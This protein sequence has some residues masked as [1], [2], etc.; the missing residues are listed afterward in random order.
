MK[1]FKENGFTLPEMMIVVA[2]SGALILGGIKFFANKNSETTKI[3]T[4]MESTLDGLNF[5][6]LLRK[7]ISEA[8]YSY[9]ALLVKDDNN[10][11]F[12]DY[13]PEGKCTNN[14][15]RVI[16]LK[17]ST[18]AAEPSKEIYFIVKDSS[19]AVEQLYDPQD[20]YN[21]SAKK[22]DDDSN[23]TFVS[24]NNNGY[25]ALK[26]FTPWELTAQIKERLIFLYS[27]YLTYAPSA[28]FGQDIGKM[29]QYL[30]WLSEKN[31]SGRLVS[32]TIKT[33]MGDIFNNQD[34]RYGDVIN[35]ED[36][37]LRRVPYTSGLG[38]FVLVAPVKVIRFRIKSEAINGKIW[39]TL[40]KGTLLSNKTFFESVLASKVEQVQFKRDTISNGSID[41]IIKYQSLK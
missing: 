24:L 34:L 30:G 26:K 35:S 27:P 23:L 40:Y 11:I 10:K 21:Y 22:S 6:A 32:E 16:T 28:K 39:G 31:L 2:V 12:F 37:M 13:F 29:V 18:K 41:T 36:K 1:Q 25:L 14:C 38:V 8:K 9:N 5:E 33:S 7:E 4:A 19:S 15:S 20:A 17:A 3:Q